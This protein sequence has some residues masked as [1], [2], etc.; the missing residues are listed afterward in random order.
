MP[1]LEI[2]WDKENTITNK[3]LFIIIIA[4]L[5]VGLTFGMVIG[6]QF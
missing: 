6:F 2:D 3:I 4:W 5:V 1:I